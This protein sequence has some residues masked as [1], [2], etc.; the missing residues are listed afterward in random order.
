MLSHDSR[1]LLAK[2]SYMIVQTT[3]GYSAEVPLDRLPCLSTG[4]SVDLC[5]AELNSPA[6]A[7]E[8]GAVSFS[9]SSG[10]ERGETCWGPW[11][12]QSQS[13][14]HLGCIPL[15]ADVI[16]STVFSKQHFNFKNSDARV[17]ILEPCCLE[18]SCT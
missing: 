14:S 16:I 6:P 5:C 9:H 1:D 11:I 13:R 17:T 8:Q 18:L 2:G 15:S 3:E 10:C 4:L 7:L 12:T